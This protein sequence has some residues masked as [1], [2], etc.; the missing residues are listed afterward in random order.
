MLGTIWRKSTR[1]GTATS[2]ENKKEADSDEMARKP[3]MCAADARKSA[4][5]LLPLFLFLDNPSERQNHHARGV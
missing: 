5:L 4:Q 1:K 2:S 3:S